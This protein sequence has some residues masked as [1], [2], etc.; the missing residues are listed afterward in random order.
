MLI[1]TQTDQVLVVAGPTAGRVIQ[2]VPNSA[3]V[4]FTSPA[5]GAKVK[6]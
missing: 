3:I 6:L 4:I 1:D 5:E 2:K